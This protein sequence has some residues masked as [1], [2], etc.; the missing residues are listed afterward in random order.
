M[1]NKAYFNEKEIKNFFNELDK[2]IEVSKSTGEKQYKRAVR[3]KAIFA[4][5]YYCALRVTEV[6]T[7]KTKSYNR[8][9]GT[10]YCDRINGSKNNKLKIKKGY[11]FVKESLDLHIKENNPGIYIFTALNNEDKPISR[12]TVN[13]LFYKTCKEVGLEYAKMNSF[14]LRDSMAMHLVKRGLTSIEL[15]YWL[16]HSNLLS[17]QKYFKDLDDK[18]IDIEEI[19]KK[20]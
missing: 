20:M 10:I 15:Q 1:E 3:N 18:N 8:K 13:V 4:T 7:L 17:T 9:E 5:M 12:K 19:Y 14:L 2:C 16:G 11:E 6:C